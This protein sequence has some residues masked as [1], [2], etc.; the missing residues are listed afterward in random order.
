MSEIFDKV[1]K[2]MKESFPEEEYREYE[3]QKELL[4]IPMYSLI[5]KLD[6]NDNLLGLL[7]SWKIG[8]FNFIE[9]L[10]INPSTRGKGIGSEMLVNF[11]K[12]ST[13]PIILEVELPN[14]EMS[15]RRIR[16]YEKLGFILNDFEYYQMPLR[17]EC[18]P[19]EMKLMS[20]PNSLDIHEFER[21]KEAIYETVYSKV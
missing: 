12:N 3:R 13:H 6:K 1:F 8:E 19:I 10:A 2:L 17:K 11:I 15:I 4:N 5:T 21:V 20:Y 16:F 7:S 18:K 14:N 9:H